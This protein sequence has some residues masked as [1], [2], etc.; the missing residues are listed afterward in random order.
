MV[1]CCIFY[2]WYLQSA[3]KISLQKTFYFLTS[4][5]QSVQACILSVRKDGG[6]GFLLKSEENDKVALCVYFQGEE[7][8]KA[9][10]ANLQ[11]YENLQITS[12]TC[13][14][15]FVKRSAD[16]KQAKIIKSGFDGIYTVVKLLG[17]TEKAL[18]KGATQNRVKSLL[19]SVSAYLEELSDVYEE[20][21]LKNFKK[22]FK[23]A[24]SEMDK[25]CENVIYLKDLRHLSCRLCSDYFDLFTNYAI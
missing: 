2:S 22:V 4:Q 18:E 6:A 9:R 17:E 25:I 12:I 21:G 7:A 3:I 19:I 24:K 10:N 15:L 1:G 23:N 16:K 5:P 11:K 8:E 14:T 20:N 13:S